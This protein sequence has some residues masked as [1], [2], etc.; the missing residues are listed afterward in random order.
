VSAGLPGG[1]P[2]KQAVESG[3]FNVRL[4][5]MSDT[6]ETIVSKAMICALARPT[7]GEFDNVNG[8]SGARSSWFR[9]VSPQSSSSAPWNS[10]ASPVE[11]GAMLQSSGH[12]ADIARVSSGGAARWK[13]FGRP[14][15][16]SAVILPLR[17]ARSA[18]VSRVALPL[19]SPVGKVCQIITVVSH[20]S[21]ATCKSKCH[22]SVFF[23]A[24]KPANC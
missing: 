2:E 18:S 10:A 16:Y 13:T 6:L 14:A 11:P 4:R 9:R 15:A 20:S 7:V 21:A 3:L 17:F 19:S 5:Q 23:G 1:R 12:R 24:E 8:C 22:T